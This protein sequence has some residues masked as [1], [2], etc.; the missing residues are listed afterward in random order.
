[1]DQELQTELLAS[2]VA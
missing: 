1:V 2:A